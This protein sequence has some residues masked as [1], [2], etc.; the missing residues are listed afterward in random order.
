MPI[1]VT[2]LIAALFA[3]AYK[4]Y[5]RKILKEMRENKVEGNFE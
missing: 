5:S 3:V 1:V 4:Y 2:G